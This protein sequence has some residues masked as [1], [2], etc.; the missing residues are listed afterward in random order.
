M[1]DD[2]KT[3]ETTKVH[4]EDHQKA[5]REIERDMRAPYSARYPLH[6]YHM[7]KSGDVQLCSG[8]SV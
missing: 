7:I 3:R 8:D 6:E 4:K 1:Y 5:A 2:A